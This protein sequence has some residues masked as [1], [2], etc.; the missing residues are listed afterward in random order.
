[1]T[2]DLL[3]QQKQ[4]RLPMSRLQFFS[5]LVLQ[6]LYLKKWSISIAFVNNRMIRKWN[7]RYL[8]HD[9]ST[10]VLAFPA[11]APKGKSKF[12]GDVVISVEKAKQQASQFGT[13]FHFELCLYM[14]HGILHLIGYKDRPRKDRERM[15]RK[16]EKVLNEVRRKWRSKK[17]KPLY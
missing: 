3:N 13:T 1:M 15:Q 2:I 7:K 10:D 4:I 16:E 8:A 5:E 9:W 11:G 12:L 6:V 14:V 17:L